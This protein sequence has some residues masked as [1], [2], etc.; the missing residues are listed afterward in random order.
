MMNASKFGAAATA[1]TIRRVGVH[2]RN[3]SLSGMEQMWPAAVPSSPDC[4][5]LTQHTDEAHRLSELRRLSSIKRE[6]EAGR[7]PL[8]FKHVLTS[9]QFDRATILSVMACATEMH[10]ARMHETLNLCKGYILGSLFFEPSTRTSSSFATAMLRLGGGVVHLDASSSSTQKG[11]SSR[12]TVKTMEQYTD[13]IA[14]RHPTV[15]SVADASEVAQNPML[16]AGDGAGEHPTQALLDCFTIIQECDV[17]SPDGLTI[18]MVGDLK[19]G[20]TVHSLSRLLSRFDNVTINYVA[21]DILRMP[22]EYLDEITAAGVR[23][24]EMKNYDEVIR[25]TDVLYMT[26]IQKERFQPMEYDEFEQS[27]GLYVL[28]AADMTKAPKD[29]V[30]MHPLP[31]VDEID[32]E[33]DADPRAAYFRQV[34]YGLSVR[35]ALLAMCLNRSPA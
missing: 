23:V 3:R 1:C 17:S 30:V 8:A 34:G 35:M 11:E 4:G 27:K 6:R 22:R 28:S 33:V 21:P 2:L 18:T 10:V 25:H 19:N 24:R 9:Q 12:D 26:R 14:M 20:R 31:R 29:M 5:A 7:N 32:V 16:N 15:G 13:I